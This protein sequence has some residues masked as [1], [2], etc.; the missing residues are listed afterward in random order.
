MTI[1]L[2]LVY[3]LLPSASAWLPFL[4]QNCKLKY[5]FF[6][7]VFSIHSPNLIE[8]FGLS[9]FEIVCSLNVLYLRGGDEVSL[10]C[11]VCCFFLIHCPLKVLFVCFHRAQR[12]L[13]KAY[14][15]ISAKVCVVWQSQRGEDL[16]DSCHFDGER[17]HLG[18]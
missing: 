5:S 1:N 11:S 18:S 12:T 17:L 2:W 14:R 8:H 4:W 16:E 9:S 6:Y 7:C 15:V 10:G 3:F 13:K